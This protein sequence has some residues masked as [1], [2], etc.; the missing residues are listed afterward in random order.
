MRPYAVPNVSPVRG[1]ALRGCGV[2]GQTLI[3]NF[4]GRF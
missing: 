1:G 3:F 4:D 2:T